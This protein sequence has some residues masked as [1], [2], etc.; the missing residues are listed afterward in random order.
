MPWF[1][2]PNCRVPLVLG[3]GL[4]VAGCSHATAEAPV[5]PLTL[6]TVSHPLERSVT[7]HNDLTGRIAAPESVQVRSRVTGYLDKINFEEGKLVKK[8]DVLFEID[9][10]P[11]QAQVN[12]ATGQLAANEALL[13]KAR[14]NNTRYKTLA[15]KSATVVTQQDLVEYQAAEDQAIGV[16]QQSKATLETN[17]L[18]L[19]FTKI[20]SPIDGRISRYNVTVG[21]LVQQE[22]TLL[23]TIVSVDPIYAYFDVDERT[24][25]HIRQLIRE[26]KAKSAREV[27]WPVML[28]LI[29]EPGYPHQG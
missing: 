29:N 10:R 9:P 8:G 28:E 13:T 1:R 17:Q 12:F 4:C 25:L 26:G 14:S 7:D 22:T 18:S 21:N 3:L 15:A 20:I 24:L 16:A 2:L 19:G 5:T 23:T 27:E 6:V 11:Y